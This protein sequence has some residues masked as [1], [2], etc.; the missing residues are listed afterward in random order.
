MV[1]IFSLTYL[2]GEDWIVVEQETVSGGVPEHKYW[3]SEDFLIKMVMSAPNKE[4]SEKFL[5]RYRAMEKEF[6]SMLLA[7]MASDESR[8]RVADIETHKLEVAERYSKLD[9]EHLGRVEQRLKLAD[10]AK[11]VMMPL[12]DRDQV[13]FKDAIRNILTTITPPGSPPSDTNEAVPRPLSI[14]PPKVKELP[15][16]EWLVENGY[17]RMNTAELK[18]LGKYVASAYRQHHNGESPP[19]RESYVGGAARPVNHYTT[20]DKEVISEGFGLMK[21]FQRK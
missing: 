6:K 11:N 3:I 18:S 5:S 14:K 17:P 4:L 16:S 1:L 21:R 15:L 19:K 8:K 13:L 20:A 10:F 9:N 12:D 2:I 7:K